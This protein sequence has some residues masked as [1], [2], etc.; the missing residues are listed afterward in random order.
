MWLL[1]LLSRVSSLALRT[2]YRL[3]VAG[4]RV[5]AEGPAL[6]VANHPNSLLD[7]ATVVAVA[8]RPVRFLAKAP[9]FSDPAVGWLVR[10]AGSI[11]VY[12][13]M[14][15]PTRMASNVDAFR[16]AHAALAEGDA[17]GIFPEGL[18]HSEPSLAPL[19]TGAARIALG[20]AALLGGP[21]PI[22]PVGLVFRRKE[23]FRSEA[24]VLVGEP[25]AWGDLWAAGTED[26]RA[27]DELTERIA[28]ALREVTVNLERW[29]DAPLVEWAAEVYAAERRMERHPAAR[30]DRLREAAEVLARLRRE[31][32]GEWRE[33]AREVQ[34]HGRILRALGLRP[35]DLR[36]T[37]RVRAAAGWTL[38]QAAF[39]LVAAPVAALGAALFRLPY[40]VTGVLE[41]RSR[42]AHDVRATYKL[43]MGAVLHL[44]WV[45]LLAG[46]AWVVWGW[47]AGV[48]ALVALPLLGAAALAVRE[49]WEE[50]VL[51]ARR[52]FQLRRRRD[53]VAELRERQREIYLRLEALRAGMEV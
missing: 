48:A 10:G 31:E 34:R 29:E 19:K 44:A 38:R 17:V 15:D 49:R 30:V 12:R 23:R 20:A 3:T 5:P 53:V 24:L 4:E 35:A 7:P 46:G 37:P 11:P 41:A 27:V 2:F 22:V 9:L 26:R 33:I 1:P 51:D 28:E 32:R 39:F 16:A 25:V 40:R 21:F 8:G 52:F 13:A 43:L 36:S 50:A 6:L 14:D 42:P 18:S 47:E 45:L